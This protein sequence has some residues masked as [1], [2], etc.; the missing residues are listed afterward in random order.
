[1]VKDEEKQNLNL[2]IKNDVIDQMLKLVTD[3][4]TESTIN[5]RNLTRNKS[6]SYVE[7]KEEIKVN[8]DWAVV[9][10]KLP[11][12]KTQDHA[13]RRKILFNHI[14]ENNKGKLSLTELDK[15]IREVLECTEIFDSE[16]SIAQAFLAAK[17]ATQRND[18][19]RIQDD[20][21][22]HPEFRVFLV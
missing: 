1:M 9:R 17:L 12:D 3:S 13:A 22:T 14:D 8:I 11:I 16:P 19:D 6:S 15:G 2:E 10:A 18:L 4:D 20:F 7:N 21:I 5:N